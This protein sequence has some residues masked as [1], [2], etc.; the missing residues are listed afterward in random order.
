MEIKTYAE[1]LAKYP[2]WVAVTIIT[3][4]ALFLGWK[5]VEKTRAY[6]RQLT[7]RW[8]DEACKAAESGD[9]DAWIKI[10]RTLDIANSGSRAGITP[11]NRATGTGD[12]GNKTNQ[13]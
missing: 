5:E 4:G 11:D 7:T 2:W 9:I 3:V 8:L 13:N 1:L 12:K 6:K 10:A